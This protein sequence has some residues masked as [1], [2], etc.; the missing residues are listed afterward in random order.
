MKNTKTTLTSLA[1]SLTLLAAL[2]LQAAINVDGTLD[3]D[4]GS[5]LAVQTINTGFGVSTIGDGTSAGGSELDAAYGTVAGGNLYLFLSGNFEA[6]GNHINVFLADGRSGQS[7]FGISGG[8]FSAMNGSKFSPGFSATYALDLNDYSGTVYTD[9]ADLVANT[10]GYAGAVGLAGGIGNGS[11]AGGIQL[12]L[13]NTH[14]STMGAA[15]TAANSA[16]MLSTMTGLELAIP[17]SLLGNPT[18]AI[19]VMADINGGNDGYLSNQFLP[20]LAVGTGNPG[21]TTFDFSSTPGEYFVVAVP[22][23]S[24]FALLGAGLAGLLW[25]RRRQ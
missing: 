20:G 19:G 3:G 4:Y 18:G 24:T 25:L 5:A 9:N 12:G 22:E 10:T 23:P 14:V 17:L 15:G 11:I 6:N 13:N 7:T 8:T 2:P 1:C 21:G 16:A